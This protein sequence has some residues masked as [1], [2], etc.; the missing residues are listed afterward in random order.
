MNQT[1]SKTRIPYL[2]FLK[3]FAIASVFLGHA[4]E[5]TTGNDFWD[6][7]IWSFI[8]TY[9]M[10]LFMLLCGYFF[11][12]SLK[13]SFVE[14]VKKK[15]MQL[16]VPSIMAWVL[17][18]LFVKLTGYNPYPE[19][20]DL[21][22]LGFMN[23]MWFLK[24]VFFCYLIGWLFVKAMKNI[25]LAALT[26][27]VIVHLI[28]LFSID[29]VNF[30]LPMFWAGYLCHL[31]QPWIDRH[32][33]QLLCASLIAFAALLPFWSGHLTVYM[34]PIDFFHWDTLTL[35]GENLGTALYRLGIGLTG[36]LVFFLLSPW[37]YERIKSW[38]I[39]PVF[40][41]LGKCTLGLYWM[42]T[43]LL[44]CTWHSIGLYVDT[45]TTFLVAPLIAVAEL[46]ICY[47]AVLLCKKNKY[48]RCLFLGEKM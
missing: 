10:P 15:F 3:F 33:K 29:S 43:F 36:S 1:T 16:G 34:V 41:K 17:M 37:V 7:P 19:I 44:E 4:T 26:S 23:A 18:F 21:S 11:G 32:R 27:T 20:V 30:L 8:Y 47:Q 46:F 5:Q 2:D 38:R 42:Q 14:L 31:Y 45:A 48:T 28:P 24:C 9:H 25:W 12:S 6:N 13:L 35:D 39:T 40:D 22:W